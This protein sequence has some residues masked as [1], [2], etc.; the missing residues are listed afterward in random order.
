M[1]NATEV[2]VT[3][4][5][6]E[7]AELQAEAAG[8]LI[9]SISRPQTSLGE[10]RSADGE[11][12]A[13]GSPVSPS[14]YMFLKQRLYAPAELSYLFTPA[15]HDSGCFALMGFLNDPMGESSQPRVCEAGVMLYFRQRLIRKLECMFPDAPTYID[16]ARCPPN[17][18]LFGID[19]EPPQICR[20]AFTAVINVP[21]WMFPSLNKQEFLHENNKPYLK[22]K[23]RCMKLMQDYL[24]RC[25]DPQALN[26]W[27]EQRAKRLSDYQDAQRLTRP[28]RRLNEDLTDEE[29]PRR[30]PTPPL[31]HSSSGAPIW[32]GQRG[33]NAGSA[34]NSAEAKQQPNSGGAEEPLAFSNDTEA[35]GEDSGAATALKKDEVG[36]DVPHDAEGPGPLESAP[37]A[38]YTESEERETKEEGGADITEEAAVTSRSEEPWAQE[39]APPS[40]APVTE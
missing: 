40:D 17:D 39:A 38:S 25:R 24:S 33:S 3:K 13:D 28:K 1:E 2:H 5:Q 23:A 36:P 34:N 12:A 37:V 29:Q 22:F 19:G 6:Q 9:A 10:K 35:A 31:A 16:A 11:L 26:S 4:E 32:T 18:R 8:G 21:E 15:D 14:L 30:S 27:L 20:Y 7:A